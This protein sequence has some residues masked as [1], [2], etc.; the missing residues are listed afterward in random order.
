MIRDDDSEYYEKI[1]IKEEL[2]KV[3]RLLCTVCK[4]IESQEFSTK[5]S[6]E[7]QE[8]WEAHKQLDAEREKE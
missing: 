1:K 7:L 8:W 6:N 4:S 3:T 5:D 2:D